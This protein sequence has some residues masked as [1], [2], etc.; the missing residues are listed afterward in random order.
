MPPTF[1]TAF[2][3]NYARRRISFCHL[4]FVVCHN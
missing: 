4:S 1:G 2:N 3:H